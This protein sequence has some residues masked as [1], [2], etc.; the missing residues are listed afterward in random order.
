MLSLGLGELTSSRKTMA[1]GCIASEKSDNSLCFRASDDHTSNAV[2]VSCANAAE[3][4][5]FRQFDDPKYPGTRIPMDKD[6]FM[7]EKTLQKLK[8]LPS[9]SLKRT[10]LTSDIILYSREQ[11]AKENAAMTKRAEVVDTSQ[12][13]WF[14]V[15]IKAQDEQF[16]LPMNPITV[17]RNALIEEGGS[18]VSINREAYAR[19][20]EYWSKHVVV[21][22]DSE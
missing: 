8:Y 18:G 3:P 14:I 1:G 4:F 5:C 2:V 22:D 17:M 13:E 16:E 21:Q 20:V 12:P 7:K 19:S 11:I 10:C 9:Q 6:A 15:A